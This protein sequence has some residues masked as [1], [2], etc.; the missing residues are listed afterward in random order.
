MD[1]FIV[2]SV[3]DLDVDGEIRV[4][5]WFFYGLWLDI[6]CLLSWFLYCC[7]YLLFFSLN[8]CCFGILLFVKYG[9]VVDGGCLILLSWRMIL[10]YNIGNRDLVEVKVCYRVLWMKDGEFLFVV[11]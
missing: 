2:F 7:F 9:S 1:R 10:L 8:I 3:L 5:I 4:D 11:V 6:V